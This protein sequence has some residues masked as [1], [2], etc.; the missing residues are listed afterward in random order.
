MNAFRASGICPLNPKAICPEELGPSASYTTTVVQS[1]PVKDA[2]AKS[3]KALED[4]MKPD[5]LKV[6]SELYNGG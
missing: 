5:T 4:L 6:F 2:N 1:H 3:L